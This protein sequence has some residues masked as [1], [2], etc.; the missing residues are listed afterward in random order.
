MR[1]FF[2]QDDKLLGALYDDGIFRKVVSR[3]KHLFRNHDGKR[4]D[5]VEAY[6][7]E[8]TPDGRYTRGSWGI[9]ASVVEQLPDGTEIRIK[10]KDEGTVYCTTKDDFIYLGTK[11]EYHE[12]SVQYI[13]YIG[14]FDTIIDGVRTKGWYRDEWYRQS[15][16]FD[17]FKPYQSTNENAANQKKST[18]QRFVETRAGRI[19]PIA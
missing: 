8:R 15:K 10:D 4:L 2:N 6:F 5:D 1:K 3:R 14:C 19:V 13:L 9:D 17:D 18:A 11:V 16:F 7:A 12:F